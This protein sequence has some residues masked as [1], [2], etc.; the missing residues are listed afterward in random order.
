MS[1]KIAVVSFAASTLLYAV[2][3]MRAGVLPAGA[4]ALWA[5]GAIQ[6]IFDAPPSDLL[7]VLGLVWGSAALWR[8]AALHEARP[9]EQAVAAQAAGQRLLALDALR[10]LI[11]VLMAIDHMRMM[12]MPHP[13]EIWDAAL[14]QYDSASPFLT[15]FVTHFCAPGFFLL[16]GVGMILFVDVRGKASWSQA[17]IAGHWILRGVLLV[18]VISSSSTR[19]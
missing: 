13:L 5:I 6:S 11:M 14:P 18:V 4:M 1:A 10:G 15:R 8:K 12:L 2:V 16:T 7:V 9:E 3:A 19:C 17:K